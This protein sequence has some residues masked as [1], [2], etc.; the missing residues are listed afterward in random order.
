[1]SKRELPAIDL[2]QPG[3]LKSVAAFG[4]SRMGNNPLY[5]EAAADLGRGLASLGFNVVYGGGQ[6]GLMGVIARSARS[7]GG[8]VTGIT[9]PF[10]DAAQGSSPEGT[11]TIVTDDIHKRQDMMMSLVEAAIF[12][13]GGFGTGEEK[14]DGLVKADLANIASTTETLIKPIISLNIA[15]FYDHERMQIERAIKDGFIP[16]ERRDFVHY[17]ETVEALFYLLLDLNGKPPMTS[18]HLTT[19]HAEAR[20]KPIKIIA[21]PPELNP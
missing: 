3:W 12:L 18:A 4:G 1:M 5:A 20:G 17:P 7:A 8:S 19:K 11:R 14:W 21:P 15:G 13:P 9:M 2:T 6:A 10:L 16:E